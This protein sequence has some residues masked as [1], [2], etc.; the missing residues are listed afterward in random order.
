MTGADTGPRADSAAADKLERAKR[1]V[2]EIKGFY[3]HLFV[4]AVVVAG[5]FVANALSSGKWWAQW[6]LLG[7]G[8]GVL[9]HGMAL[10]VRG[11]RRVADWEQRKIRQLMDEA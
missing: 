9:A 10:L 7:W 2:A 1:R 3:I 11:S 5:L 4:F 8:I 6:V